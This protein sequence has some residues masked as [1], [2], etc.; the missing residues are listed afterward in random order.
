MVIAAPPKVVAALIL[1]T[2][3]QDLHVK[4]AVHL[5][6]DQGHW[7]A[8]RRFVRRFVGTASNGTK[9][10]RWDDLGQ[11]FTANQVKP[12]DVFAEAPSTLR[13]L[14]HLALTR[15]FASGLNG[16]QEQLVAAAFAP[17]DELATSPRD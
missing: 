2:L 13:T 12:D 17:T 14:L 7:L 11:A 15:R 6:I 4:R 9:H 16:R 1:G 8:D 5:L 10:V 3:H